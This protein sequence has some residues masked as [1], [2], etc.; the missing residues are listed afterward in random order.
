MHRD[1]SCGAHFR[2][3]YGESRSDAS[4][5]YVA[6]WKY[7]GGAPVPHRE[8]LTFTSVTPTRRSYR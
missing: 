2:I 4:C 7:T 5:A 8:P 6:A 3:E 1:E